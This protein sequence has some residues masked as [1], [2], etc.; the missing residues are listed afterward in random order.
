MTKYHWVAT[1]CIG[2]EQV[3]TALNEAEEN[4]SVDTRI[5]YC[6][7]VT[8]GKATL[9]SGNTPTQMPYFNIFIRVPKGSGVQQ[10]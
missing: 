7:H 5:V 8:V 2:M 10:V 3:M 9:I 4:G 6:G 1:E